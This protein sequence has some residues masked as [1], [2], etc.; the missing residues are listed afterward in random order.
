MLYLSP[1]D[2]GDHRTVAS[3]DVRN[4]IEVEATSVDAL[5][6]ARRTDIHFAKL[7]IQGAEGE[8]LRGMRATLASPRF[9]GLVLEFWPDALRRAG[10][11]PRAIRDAIHLGGLRCTSHPGLDGDPAG[12]LAGIREHG[13]QDLLF[14]RP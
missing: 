5:A 8:A 4:S 14:L 6:D 1:R 3:G 11:D 2:G 9:R 13:S 7:D 12:F 10:E